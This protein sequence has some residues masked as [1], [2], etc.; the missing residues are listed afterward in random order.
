[1]PERWPIHRNSSNPVADWPPSD[2]G[3]KFARPNPSGGA[4]Y[5]DYFV[6]HGGGRS[7]DGKALPP[8]P[9]IEYAPDGD[10][11]YGRSQASMRNWAQFADSGTFPGD[12]N[13]FNGSATRL[14]ALADNTP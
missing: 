7:K 4:A 14:S 3:A 13:Q 2:Q 11:R 5:P 1:M 10:Q 8:M 12:Q 9:D 6:A